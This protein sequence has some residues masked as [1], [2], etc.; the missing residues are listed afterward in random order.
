MSKKNSQ[1]RSHSESQLETILPVAK[2]IPLVIPF[3]Y[4]EELEKYKKISKVGQG[5]YG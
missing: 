1:K 3:P 2:K 4:S 5:S